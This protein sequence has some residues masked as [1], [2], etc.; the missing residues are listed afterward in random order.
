MTRLAIA[1]DLGTSGFRAQALDLKAGEIISTAITTRHPLPGA[2]VI[3]HLH[4]A[5]EMGVEVAATIMLEAINKVLGRLQVP[6]DNVVRLAVCGN[7]IQLSLFQRIEIRDLAFAGKRKL[8]ALGVIPPKRDATIL[9]AA[10]V[11]GLMIPAEADVII[12]PAVRHEIGADALAMMIQTGMLEKDEISLT[13]DYGTN[14]EMALFHQGEVITG[15][16]AAGP[17]LEGQQIECG[18][19]A[20]PGAISDLANIDGHYRLIVLDSNMLPATGPLIDIKD[21]HVWEGGEIDAVGITGTGTVAVLS[22]GM[23]ANLITLPRINTLDT[24]FHLTSDIYFTEE[25]LKEAGKAI[26]SVRAGHITLCHEAGIDLGD[27]AVAYMSG[28]SGTYV[29]A[30]KAQRLGMIPPRVKTIYQV[31]NTSLAMARDLVLDPNQLETMSNLAKNLRQTHCMFAASKVFEKIYI[32]ELSYWTEGMPFAQYQAF[33]KRYGF[34]ELLTIEGL[35]EVIHTVHRDIDDLGY[36]GLTTV[37]DIGQVV[38][39]QFEG[40]IA[41]LECVNSCPENAI[42][43]VEDSEPPLLMLDQ[44][45]CNGVACRRCERACPQKGFKLEEFFIK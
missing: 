19:L 14:A 18:M 29:D 2:N 28:A 27:V 32:L 11:P 30:L 16:T 40:C 4:F 24:E 34:P 3:D 6:L 41:C 39:V 45:L 17:A 37:P 9:R 7:P 12:P 5:L 20:M 8:D 35:P 10:D 31:G 33:L 42:R 23:D 36:L 44:S 15:S 38:K 22:Q 1:M 25:D 43:L 21:G 13:T 26:G